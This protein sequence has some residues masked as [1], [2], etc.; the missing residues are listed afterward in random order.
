MLTRQQSSKRVFLL[1]SLPAEGMRAAGMA[2]KLVRI[3][4][5]K[6]KG[7]KEP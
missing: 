3:P 2:P 7:A 4:F 1:K 5:C 6:R